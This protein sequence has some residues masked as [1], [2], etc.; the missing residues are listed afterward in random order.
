MSAIILDGK[1]LANKIL[2]EVKIKA[3]NFKKQHEFPP[4]LA[5]ILVGEDE[6]S[7]LYVNSKTKKCESSGICAENIFFNEDIDEEALLNKIEE[8]N[9]DKTVHGM[10]VQQPFPKNFNTFK[11]IN[12]VSPK[13][14]VDGF[15]PASLG[16]I[17]YNKPLFIPCTPLGIMKLLK[18]YNIDIAGK[19]AVILGRSN[20]V[21]KP[22]ALLLL[23]EHATVTICHTKTKDIK[24]TAL[25]AD[26]LISAIGRPNFVTGDMIK[27]GAVVVD[28]GIN[29]IN[30]KV[31]GD[32][33]FEK[34]KEKASY[35]TPVPGGVGPLTIAM[36]LSNTVTAAELSIK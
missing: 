1:L 27:E 26:I 5:T 8:L 31:T 18:E 19:N 14:D 4:K 25:G 13:K 10:L 2:D 30:G 35:I 15:H 20:I 11:I 24:Q 7:K 17:L 9:N 29:R 34:V 6:A 22:L 21:G 33:D 3:E 16:N 28:V 36:L 32:V 12:A 23:N